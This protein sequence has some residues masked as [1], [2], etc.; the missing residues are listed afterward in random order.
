LSVSTGTRDPLN[1]MTTEVRH[2]ADVPYRA[3]NAR[4]RERS[5]A[6]PKNI[7]GEADGPAGGS[8]AGRLCA[9]PGYAVPRILRCPEMFARVAAV[10]QKCKQRAGIIACTATVIRI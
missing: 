10:L 4:R 1:P 3:E 2:D 9:G 8:S 6:G 5:A 7:A